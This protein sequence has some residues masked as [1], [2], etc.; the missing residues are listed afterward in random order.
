MYGSKRKQADLLIYNIGQL[1]TVAGANEPRVGDD[2]QHLGIL[3]DSAIVIKE[4]RIEDIGAQKDILDKWDAKDSIDAEGNLVTPGLVDPHTHPV[5]GPT[6]EN[7]FEMRVRGATYLEIAAAGGG[8]RN[9]VRKLRETPKE[10]LK[11]LT[12]RRLDR[13]LLLG[14][15]TIE[16]KS[17]YGLSLEHEIKS[18]EILKELGEEML[19]DI[20]PTFLGA[21]EIPDEYQNNR[22]GYIKLVKDEMI[23]EVSK[24]D[25]AVFCDVFCEDKVVNIEESRDILMAAKRYGLKLKLH[26]DEFKPLGGAQ[27]AAELGAISAD[28][29]VAISKDGIKA[30]RDAGVIAVLLPGTSFFLGGKR[31]APARDMIDSGVAVALSTDFNPGS[32]MT[33][34]MQMIMTLATLYLKMLPSEALVACTINSACAIGVQDK[35]GSL[36]KGKQADIVIWDAPNYK[37]IPY[38]FGDN[39]CKIVIKSGKI[40]KS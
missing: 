31:Y 9:S 40:L 32:S 28:H 8:I 34:S 4:D 25:L 33:Q 24:R 6:R 26:A 17:G 19:L 27:L 30:M 23:P 13:F 36:I 39:L 10:R 3:E 5:F 38:H 15:T 21:H 14:T 18:L 20:I 22:D 16:A 7:E 1:V 2:M 37:Y 12:R 29:L 35:V 11:D